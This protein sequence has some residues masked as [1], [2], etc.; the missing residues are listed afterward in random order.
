MN[1]VFQKISE[2]ID[3]FDSMKD[4]IENTLNRLCE[5]SFVLDKLDY[6]DSQA[7]TTLTVKMS[8]SFKAK[9]IVDGEEK[10]EIIKLEYQHDDIFSVCYGYDNS[11]LIIPSRKLALTL[12]NASFK[13]LMQAEF[14]LIDDSTNWSF[15]AEIENTET[16]R[17]HSDLYFYSEIFFFEK[18]FDEMSSI[19]KSLNSAHLTHIALLYDHNYTLPDSNLFLKN[20][21]E[22]DHWDAETV[23][24]WDKKQE[25]MQTIFDA[26]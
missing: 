21:P 2:I 7:D 8:A 24:I 6:L 4:S 18:T 15:V 12:N 10:I 13:K 26:M 17:I 3:N 19:L 14:S 22:F 25:E 9:A 23:N 11:R 20:N 1:T 5:T 16:D